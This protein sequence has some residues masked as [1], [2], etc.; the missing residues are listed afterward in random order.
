M[1]IGLKIWSV[2]IITALCL[3]IAAAIANTYPAFGWLGIAAVTV[4]IG[5]VGFVL[6]RRY[7]YGA[8]RRVLAVE[9]E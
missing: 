3:V 6:Y 2:V 4:V 7:R 8:T 9:M 5:A 1:N